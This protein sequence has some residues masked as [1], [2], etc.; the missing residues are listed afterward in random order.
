MDENKWWNKLI[1]MSKEEFNLMPI[2]FIKKYGSYL[3]NL[4]RYNREYHMEENK[5]IDG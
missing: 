4:H 3:N 1:S 5:A 2:G